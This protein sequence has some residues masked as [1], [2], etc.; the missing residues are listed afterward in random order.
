[1]ILSIIS[2]TIIATYLLYTGIKYGITKS[3]S[4]SYYKL[5]K[6]EKPLFYFTL[7]G[8]SVTLWLSAA[9]NINNTVTVTILGL[10]TFLIAIVGVASAY[11]EIFIGRIHIIGAVSGYILGY[12]FIIV[13]YGWS[14]I[15]LV[16][17]SGLIALFVA[18]WYDRHP[19]W[20]NKNIYWIEVIGMFTIWLSV[21]ITV[22]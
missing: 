22:I 21:L 18:N 13:T 5:N 16:I 19:E 10:A 1:M 9:I 12:L 4:E 15:F 7:A 17:P 6:Y 14:S 20:E 2:I 8:T 11:K 3:I